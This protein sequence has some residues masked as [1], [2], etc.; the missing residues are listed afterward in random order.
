[1]HRQFFKT[2]SQN[3]DYVKTH[4]N[5]RNNPFHFS[6]RKWYLYINPQC[7]TRKYEIIKPLIHK[8]G[9]IINIC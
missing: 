4:C 2:L 3:P 8:I 5:D 6:N 9:P 7:T 1:M